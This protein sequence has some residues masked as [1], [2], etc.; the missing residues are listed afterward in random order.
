MF[1]SCKDVISLNV[2]VARGD[3]QSFNLYRGQMELKGQ[4]KEKLQRRHSFS[5][6]PGHIKT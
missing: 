2:S 3:H 6:K 1:L 5:G 4:A